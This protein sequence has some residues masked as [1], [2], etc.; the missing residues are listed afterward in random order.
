MTHLCSRGSKLHLV[1]SCARFHCR[2]ETL[3]IYI[4]FDVSNNP[5]DMKDILEENIELILSRLGD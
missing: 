3:Q 1:T 4:S 2:L 5:V